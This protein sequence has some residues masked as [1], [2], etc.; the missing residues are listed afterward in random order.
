MVCVREMRSAARRGWLTMEMLRT[1]SFPA[2]SG[3]SVPNPSDC[4][5]R[6]LKLLQF[7]FQGANV[8]VV[9]RADAKL[10]PVQVREPE[11]MHMLT[12]LAL[13]SLEEANYHGSGGSVGMS[14]RG[15]K[16]KVVVEAK[17]KR[18]SGRKTAAGQPI[19]EKRSARLE[20]EELLRPFA[21]AAGDGCVE[22]A[23][24]TEASLRLTLRA[25]RAG[26]D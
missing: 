16:Q 1:I 17:W 7:K 6:V 9:L 5:A 12:A 25:V 11:L 15:F 3:T 24:P 22:F 8:E 2:S 13:I 18:A 14:V 23:C 26:S 20:R 10:P 21:A 19:A 4:M